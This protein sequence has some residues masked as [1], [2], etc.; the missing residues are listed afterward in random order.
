MGT[1]VKSRRRARK[2]EDAANPEDADQDPGT[3]N[4]TVVTE[5]FLLGFQGSQLLRNVLFFLFLLVF[6]ATICINL[7]IILLTSISKILHTPMYFFISQLA[8]SDLLLTTDIVPNLLLTVL[9]NGRAISFVGCIT[10]LYFSLV[11]MG[12]DCLLLTVM[13]YDRY[14]AICNPL[15][16][17]T[18]MTNTYCMKLAFICWLLG[19]LFASVD[20]ITPALL[21]FCGPNLIDHLF[22][23]LVPV[24][25][26]VCSDTSI[27]Q[28]EM[29]LLSIPLIFFPILM[30]VYSYVNIIVNILRIPSNTGR[31]KA[32]ST[33]SSH[34]IVVSIFYCTLF[35]IYVFP[36]R[37][38]SSTINKI[39]CLL[40]TMFIPLLNPIIYSLRNKD[41]RKAIRDTFPTHMT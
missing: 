32:F 14:V 31:Q 12:F 28:L 6:G 26:N 5:F 36:T 37:G 35:S 2:T 8:I 30:I 39:T 7:L 41:I 1:A 20:T 22:C 13:S 33:C 4:L 3:E 21:I 16:Y 19:F 38:Q 23:D 40:Y 18:I 17:V 11:P 34:L 25:G 24:L 10:Q 9:M 29:F 15:R 27:V